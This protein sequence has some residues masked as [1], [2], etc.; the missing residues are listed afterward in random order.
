MDKSRP[1]FRNGSRSARDPHRGE[2]RS[3][4]GLAPADPPAPRSP[5]EPGGGGA[6]TSGGATPEASQAAARAAGVAENDGLQ[7]KLDQDAPAP[8]AERLAQADLAGP[9]GHGHQ[10]DVHDPDARHDQRAE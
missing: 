8:G 7:Q 2:D 3:L 6:K 10:H 9:F 1:S 4:A 5:R